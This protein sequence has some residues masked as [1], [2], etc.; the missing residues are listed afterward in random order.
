MQQKYYVVVIDDSNV[1]VTDECYYSTE[2]YYVSQTKNEM[3]MINELLNEYRLNFSN[4]NLFTLYRPIG[5]YSGK[6]F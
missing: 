2:I 4:D 3:E 6:I 5:T 1:L